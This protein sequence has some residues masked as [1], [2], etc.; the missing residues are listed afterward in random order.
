MRH[1]LRK[2]AVIAASAVLVA[3]AAWAASYTNGAAQSFL[4]QPNRTLPYAASFRDVEGR[5][6]L[7]RAW[8]NGV[9]S[10][11]FAIDTGA[12]ATIISERVAQEAR[13]AIKRGSVV[14]IGGLSGAGNATG[15]EALVRQLAI[16]DEGNLLP[17]RGEV[18]VTGGLPQDI[19][20]VLDPTESYWPLG[21]VIDL[22]RG[23]ISAFDPRTN[24]LRRGDEPR[25]GTVVNWIFQGGSRRPFVALQGGQRALIDTGSGFGL[26]VS[27]EAARLLGLISRDGR[28]KG[29]VRDLGGGRVFA[30][31]IAPANVRVGSM[32]LRRVPTDL[33]TGSASGSPILLGRE[34]LA[35]FRLTFDPVNKL[36]QIAP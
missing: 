19:D 33:L 16:G 32:E 25:G 4:R 31:R 15:R 28:E 14:N 27:E 18:I 1:A 22:P 23:E 30:R 26:A 21:Y 36:I 6:L 10:Y 3:L 2:R 5:G 13:V 9:G 29:S 35:P 8:V 7:V 20:G 11:T 24:P 34:A 12:G 17:S